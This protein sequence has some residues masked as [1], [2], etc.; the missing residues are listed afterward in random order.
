MEPSFSRLILLTFG[1]SLHCANSQAQDVL[2]VANKNLTVAQISSAE[3]HDIFTGVRSRLSGGSLD[4]PVT[5]KGGAVHE[6]FLKNYVQQN[7]DEFRVCWRKIVF[8][9]KGSMIKDFSTEAALLEYVSSTAGAI[10]HVSRVTDVNSV[11]V[12]AVIR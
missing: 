1:F 8:T 4:V 10:G 7:P 9:G 5:L 3:L 12:L 11:R 6:V 2:I